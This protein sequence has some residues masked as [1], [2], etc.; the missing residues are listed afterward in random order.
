MVVGKVCASIRRMWSTP[1]RPAT[2]L[3]HIAGTVDPTGVTTPIPVTTTR[4]R[5][6]IMW[7]GPWARQCP[8]A[9]RCH[10]RS[11]HSKS[12][13]D[14]RGIELAGG[15]RDVEHGVHDAGARDAPA[16]HARRAGDACRIVGDG[17]GLDRQV[18]P[19]ARPD[20]MQEL[21]VLD[22]GQHRQHA[23]AGGVP[24]TEASTRRPPSWAS[25][26]STRTP[27]TSG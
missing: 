1:D 18:E 4:R 6:G 15:G 23:P 3:S 7:R 19:V 9:V 13:A 14:W 12:A 2:R 22:L 20:R 25:D 10:T 8:G 26:S 5:G 27:G 24:R 17:H 11:D 16:A 21:G